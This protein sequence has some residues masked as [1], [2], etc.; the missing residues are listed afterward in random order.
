M[1]K[2][3]EMKIRVWGLAAGRGTTKEAAHGALCIREYETEEYPSKDWLEI[4][5]VERIKK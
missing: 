2:D 3:E 4:I 5:A 1:T